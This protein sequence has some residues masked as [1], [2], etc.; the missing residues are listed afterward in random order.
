M[1]SDVLN[2]PVQ[3][4]RQHRARN[5]HFC[6]GFSFKSQ[7]SREN[8][9]SIERSTEA[10]MDIYCSQWHRINDREKQCWTIR[11]RRPEDTVI[12]PLQETQQPI[13]RRI[14]ILRSKLNGAKTPLD[15]LE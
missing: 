2:N 8:T 10:L 13:Q 9:S 4:S 7:S 12:R 5:I 15:I 3:N 1:E 14:E 11:L 6:F